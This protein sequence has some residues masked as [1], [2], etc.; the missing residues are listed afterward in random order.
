MTLPTITGTFRVVSAPELRFTAGG[1]AVA[2]LT[3]ITNER[4]KNQSDEWED[5]DGTPFLNV[6]LWEKAAE[7]LAEVNLTTKDKVLVTGQFFQRKYEKR[8]GTEGVSFE[9]KNAT[10]AKV[11]PVQY[12]DRSSTPRQASTP[13][14]WGTPTHD[15]APF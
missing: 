14:P 9:I 3:V 8:D 12:A 4:R 10:V 15:Q 6:T 13:D 11:P 2:T 1:K 7:A 5:G